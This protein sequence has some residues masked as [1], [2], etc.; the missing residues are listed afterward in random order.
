MKFALILLYLVTIVL[1][2]D[3]ISDFEICTKKTTDKCKTE[4]SCCAEISE[5]MNGPSIGPKD[6]LCIPLGMSGSIPIS[7]SGDTKDDL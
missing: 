5:T 6:R 4:T 7:I 3:E 1:A 2:D